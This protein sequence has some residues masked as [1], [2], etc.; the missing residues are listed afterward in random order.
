MSTLEEEIRDLQV[1]IV[2]NT[3]RVDKAVDEGNGE[4]EKML[5]VV[6]LVIDH[7][8]SCHFVLFLICIPKNETDAIVSVVFIF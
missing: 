5:V 4:D 2:K 1:E 8:V 3:V 7:H 6:L